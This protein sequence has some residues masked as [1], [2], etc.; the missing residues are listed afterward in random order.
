[1]TICTNKENEESIRC[2]KILT[3]IVLSIIRSLLL[4]LQDMGKVRIKLLILLSGLLLN[5]LYVFTQSKPITFEYLTVDDGLSDNRIQSIYRDHKDYLWIGTSQGLNKFDGSNITIFE[6]MDDQTGS[7]SDNNIHCIYEDASNNLWIG[8][9]NGLNLFNPQSGTFT[10]FYIDLSDSTLYFTNNITCILEDHTGNLWVTYNNSEVGL[11]KWDYT[12]NSYSRYHIKGQEIRLM[13]IQED[14][15]GRLWIVSNGSGVYH[16]DPN[17]EKFTF[18]NDPEINTGN[19]THK[20]LFIDNK[21]ILWIGTAGNG[22]YTFDPKTSKFRHFGINIGNKGVNHHQ[23]YDIIQPDND[24]LLIGTD[25]GGINK[26]NIKSETFEYIEQNNNIKRGLNTNGILSLFQDKEG[27]LWVGTSRGGVNYSNP[28]QFKF[29]LFERNDKNQ[30]SLSYNIIGCFYEDAQGVIWIGTD[31]GGLNAYDPKSGNFKIYKHDPANPYSISGNVIRCIDEDIDNDLWIG[32]WDAGLNRYDRS[33]GNFY[34]YFP[35]KNDP[36]SIS[37][38]TSWYLKIDHNNRMWVDVFDKGLEIFSKQNGVVNRFFEDPE[39][40]RSL[41]NNFIWLI[42]EDRQHNIWI[43]KPDGI[44]LYDSISNSFTIYNHFPDNDISAFC[45]DREGKLWAGSANKGLFLFEMDGTVVKTYDKNKG[46]AN[47]TIHAIVEDDNGNLWIS[48]NN[49]ISHFNQKTQK[50]RNYNK[51]DGLQGNAFF[52]QSFLKTRNG[53]I[54]FGGFNG[55]NSFHPDSVKDNYFVPNVYITG[56]KLFNKPVPIGTKGSPLQYHINETKQITLNWRQ[57]VFSFE[58]CAIN[59]THPEKNEYAYMMEGFEKEWN[60]VGNKRDATYTNLDAGEYVFRVKASNNDG[61]WNEEGTS[62]KLI[63]NPPFWNTWWFKLIIGLLIAMAI[64]AIYRMRVSSLKNQKKKLEVQ[65]TKRTQELKI[66]Y[67]NIKN[68]SDFGQKITSNL[69]YS[70]INKMINNYLKTIFDDFD[71]GIGIFNPDKEVIE[72]RMFFKDGNLV[73][74]YERPLSNKNSFSVY[75]IEN[76]KIVFINNLEKEYK[77]YISEYPDFSASRIPNSIINIPLTVKGKKIGLLAINSMKNDAFSDHDLLKLQTLA[78]YIAIALDNAESHAALQNNNKLLLKRQK[79]IEEQSEYINE[80]NTLLEERQQQIEEQSEELRAQTEELFAANVD[81]KNSNATKDKLFSI[82]AHDLKNPFN[83]VLGFSELILNKWDKIENSKMKQ[84]VETIY[85]S[86]K[87]IFN[88]LENLLQWSTSQ[89]GNIRYKPENILLY[90]L[91]KENIDLLSNL[92]TQKNNSVELN[93]PKDLYCFAD[94]QMIKTVIRNLLTN[95]IKYTENGT[96]TL[97][98]EIQEDR[99][100]ISIEDT[101]IGIAEEKLVNLFEVE[102][103][104]S[105]R[106]TQGEQGTGL[107]LILCK[108]LV[109]NNGGMIVAKSIVNKG[110][111]VVFTLPMHPPE[112]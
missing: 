46:L 2:H 5:P 47:N 82:I 29:K 56:F 55:F 66:A 107:G 89:M 84:M 35:D 97:S 85:S 41:S 70:A 68:I 60:Y 32:T 49:G 106:G 75:C 54:Y 28:K 10:K 3:V 42:Y 57:S 64:Y 40:P 90:N 76:Q 53:E 81:L 101:G 52:Q 48:T 8:T 98:S 112:N 105:T 95:A 27:I 30:N 16:F 94:Q 25:Q 108:E 14:S 83:A 100:I 111:T 63:V 43:C 13:S 39:N 69:D 80:T 9:T 92:I 93:I 78:A 31:G 36:S 67:G 59:Y 23:V 73:S 1:M 4:F 104:K 58:F 20:K 6:Q 19:N 17:T 72:Y 22:L 34:H 96:I 21:D 12:K 33:T 88:L 18:Y 50:F 51:S 91:A 44:N 99:V 11:V 26:F 15:K 38:K 109:V 79:K 65:V 24:Y 71:F 74:P 103:S 45:R 77:K 102:K 62:I 87:N 110:S 86:S 61:V 7:I 37:S